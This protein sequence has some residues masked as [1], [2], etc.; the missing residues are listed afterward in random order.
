MENREEN[1]P[2]FEEEA[3]SASDPG[4]I[5]PSV[6][7]RPPV[8]TPEV[9]SRSDMDDPLGALAKGLPDVIQRAK[10]FYARHPTLVKTVGTVFV[11]AIARRLF[12][13]RPGLF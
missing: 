1:T 5:D 10:G 9:E 11:A 4:R 6:R 12:R 8:V 13:G 3:V 2:Q 7:R